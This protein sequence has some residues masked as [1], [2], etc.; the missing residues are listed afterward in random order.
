[1]SNKDDGGVFV[2]LQERL[3]RNR[4]LFLAALAIAGVTAFAVSMNLNMEEDFTVM[5]PRGDPVVDAIRDTLV[6]FRQANRLLVDIGAEAGDPGRVAAAAADFEA[7]IEGLPGLERPAAAGGADMQA[8]FRFLLD[9][10]PAAFGEEEAREL[11]SAL[12]PAAVRQHLAWLKDRLSGPYGFAFKEI[13][14]NDPV[15]LSRL[16][17][18]RLGGLQAMTGGASMQDG[19][20]R[21]PDGLH[22]MLMLQTPFASSDSVRGA[23]VVSGLLRAARDVEAR[24]PGVRVSVAGAHRAALDNGAM[25]RADATRTMTVGVGLMMALLCGL[26]RRK[27][28]VPLT[29]FPTFYGALLAGAVMASLFPSLSAIALGCASIITGVGVDYAIHVLYHIEDAACRTPRDVGNV[30]RGLFLPVLIGSLTT[31]AAFMVMLLSNVPGHRQLGLFAGMAVL[32]SDIIALIVLPALVRLPAGAGGRKRPIIFTRFMAAFFRVRAAHPVFFA[33]LAAVFTLGG[34]AGVARLDFDGDLM[35]MNGVYPQ[36][37][38]DEERVQ[39]VWGDITR[40]TTVIIGGGNEAEALDKCGRAAAAVGRLRAAGRVESSSFV[41]DICPAP[42]DQARNIERWRAFWSPARAESARAAVEDAA[43]ELGFSGDA[44]TPFYERLSAPPQTLTLAGFAGLPFAPAVGERASLEPGNVRLMATIKP[45]RGVELEEI[46][47]AVKAEAP[48]AVVYDSRAIARHM[49]D[50]A[51]SGMQWFAGL[52]F[53]V[54][55]L[56]LFLMVGRLDVTAIGV[57]PVSASLLWTLGLMGW[58]GLPL[59]TMNIVFVIFLF[60]VGTDYGVFLTLTRLAEGNRGEPAKRMASSGASVLTCALTTLCGFGVLVFARHPALFSIGSTALMG[61]LISLIATFILAPMGAEWL[62]ARAERCRSAPPPARASG[63]AGLRR[64]VRRLYSYQGAV[65]EQFVKWK[66]RTDPMFGALDALAPRRGT[67]LD[68]GCG[69]GLAANWLALQ[70]P[71][72]VLLGYDYDAGKISSASESAWRGG[73]L[74]FEERD[75]LS[76][77]L[78]ESDAVLLLDVLHYWSADKQDALLA[79]IRAA[80][81]PGGRLIMRDAMRDESAAHSRVVFWERFATA[82]SHNRAAEKMCFR[83]LPDIRAALER[84]GFRNVTGVQGRTGLGSNMLITAE[85]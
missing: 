51:R 4:R 6:R 48:D 12:D 68:L 40:F 55:V 35:K 28:M 18:A 81:R 73:R 32:A 31:V 76:C 63:P 78:P 37:R 66:L 38:A 20:L 21:S 64:F 50:S 29:F 19:R 42:A 84:A 69:H 27:S 53:G 62:V 13:A 1:M 49:A 45:A 10:L 2:R 25:I 39:D 23:P 3:A 60:G 17:G 65:T 82:I 71:E 36:T 54:V 79:R 9:S 77:A 5:L 30:I 57:L 74:R 14:R 75:I 41:S 22:E 59:N 85:T 44:F 33:A 58:L 80:L 34:I 70:A 43:S 7:A 15:G 56:A 24:H 47:A 72:R 83:S 11:E 16:V 8:S 26:Y 61:M 52:S 67:I 46:E